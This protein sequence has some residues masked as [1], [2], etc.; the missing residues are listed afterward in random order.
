MVDV[1]RL[2]K[3]YCPVVEEFNVRNIMGGYEQKEWMFSYR[4]T[5]VGTT[6]DITLS[7]ITGG[8]IQ[9]LEHYHVLATKLN[10][11]PSNKTFINPKT[12]TQFTLNGDNAGLY[13]IIILGSE[14]PYQGKSSSIAPVSFK[15]LT[16]KWAKDY[17]PY[18]KAFNVKTLVGGVLKD[19]VAFSFRWTTGSTADVIDFRTATKV[20]DA[21]N[22]A[23]Q[24]KPYLVSQMYDTDYG[25]AI[26]KNDSGAASA[27][28][29]SSLTKTGFTLN[30]ENAKAYDVLIVGQIQY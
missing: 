24:G 19:I 28:Y 11:L 25:I 4:H 20:T 30:G 9:K 21:N 2:F 10:A 5:L 14:I 6:D 23:G 12:T 15:G 8:F 7:T 18:C 13:S 29:P 27:I 22:S 26:T 3:E 16:G 17:C 1:R